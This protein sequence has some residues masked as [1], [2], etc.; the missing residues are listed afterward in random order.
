[1]HI[2]V[3]QFDLLIPGAQSLKDKRRV[4]RSVKDRLHREHLVS[5]AE[6][7][8]LEDHARAGMAL[9]AVNRDARYLQGVLDTITDK[10]RKLPEAQLG[11]CEREV[12]DGEQLPGAYAAEDGSPLWT[13]DESREM[14]QRGL[15][16]QETDGDQ[17]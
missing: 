10:L 2:A 17:P 12:L 8:H 11:Y 5:V 4:V 1:M 16:G 6:V 3:L 14:I 9:A 15:E 7:R 13:A